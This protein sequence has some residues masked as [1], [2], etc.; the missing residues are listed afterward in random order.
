MEQLMCIALAIYFEARGESSLGQWAV[1]NVV[2]NRI[3]DPRYPSDACAVVK[4]GPWSAGLPVRHKCQFSFYCDG[5]P[6]YVFDDRAWM[7]AMRVAGLSMTLDIVGGATHYH[8]LQVAP[9]W[10]SGM[11]VTRELGGRLFF[12]ER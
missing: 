9:E 4:Q 3:R 5:K 8:T 10:S 12:I 7:K 11:K 6:E 2:L 1:G